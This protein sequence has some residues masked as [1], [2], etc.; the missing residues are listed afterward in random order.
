MNST[1]FTSRRLTV[2][3]FLGIALGAST[4][5][6]GCDD[7]TGLD[8]DSGVGTETSTP[9]GPVVAIATAREQYKAPEVPI[10]TTEPV[11]PV[12]KSPPATS[13]LVLHLKCD[14]N[15]ANPVVQ[16][17]SKSQNNQ[18]MLD[19]TGNSHTANHSV[20]GVVDTAL[21]FDG[22]D[23]QVI[24]PKSQIDH[25]F[26]ANSDFTVALWWRSDADPFP[27]GYRNIIGNYG[28]DTGGIILYQ[29]GLADGLPRIYLQFYVPNIGAPIF[30]PST[31]HADNAG[32]WHHYVFQRERNTLLVWRDGLPLGSHTDEAVRENMGEGSDLRLGSDTTG[33]KGALDDFRVYDRALSKAEI[34]ALAAS[35]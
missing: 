14:D 3:S 7:P 28:R 29:R 27:D 25:V 5:F 19:A 16:D 24:V 15:A 21:A 26:V 35:R 1:G 30:R 32:E 9:E 6:A 23:D 20:P 34:M 13:A 4:M 31:S 17:A 12:E 11:P 22:V 10:S 8:S 2:T 33:A 18:A